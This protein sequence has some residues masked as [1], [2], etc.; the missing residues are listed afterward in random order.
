MRT[1]TAILLLIILWGCGDGKEKQSSIPNGQ[2]DTLQVDNNIQISPPTNNIQVR[3]ITTL[4]TKD[5]VFGYVPKGSI[6]FKPENAVRGYAVQGIK[7]DKVVATFYC[8]SNN[9]KKFVSM[10]QYYIV[11]NDSLT[12]YYN[13]RFR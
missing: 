11:G 9:L 2:F 12:E 3:V 7:D 8:D 10:M 6:F 13:K 5:D 4:L 1:L